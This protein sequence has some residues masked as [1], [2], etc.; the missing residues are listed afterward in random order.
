MLKKFFTIFKRDKSGFS[1]E[2]LEWQSKVGKVVVDSLKSSVIIL[3]II[4]AIFF[5][6][7]V[8]EKFET[9]EWQ[10]V[11][12]LSTSIATWIVAFVAGSVGVLFLVPLD[13]IEGQLKKN[14]E[15]E[16]KANILAEL[17]EGEFSEYDLGKTVIYALQSGWIK[18]VL[19]PN[20]K[21]EV[22]KLNSDQE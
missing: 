20:G 8:H 16:E 19:K 2:E 5:G 7:I 9:S 12:T 10:D 13:E 15:K 22:S 11:L 4:L 21:I 6:D 18:V 17:E 1:N 3:G 14:R